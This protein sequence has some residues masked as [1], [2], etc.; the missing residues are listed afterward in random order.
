MKAAQC[1]VAFVAFG[2]EIFTALVPIRVRSENRNFSAHIVRWMKSAFA[3]HMR[4]HCRSG[5]FAV[6]SGDHNATLGLHDCSDGFGA[7]E[8][9]FSATTRASKNWIVLLN[10]GGKNNKVRSGRM[11]SEM[12]FMK[13]QA[14]PLQSL[15]LCRRNLV[16]AA[17]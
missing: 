7:T 10:R 15:G 8:Q 4:G 14:K 9:W 17:H 2:N 16:R 3:K 13:A 5:R 12:L 1:A 6:H 11:L